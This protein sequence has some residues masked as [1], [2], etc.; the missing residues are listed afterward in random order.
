MGEYEKRDLENSRK[1]PNRASRNKNVVTKIKRKISIDRLNSKLNT[2]GE[3]M[4]YDRSRE[5]SNEIKEK[6][7]I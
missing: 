2:T 3:L 6:V 5:I 1:E 4:N 7:K